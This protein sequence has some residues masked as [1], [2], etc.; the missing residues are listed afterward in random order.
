VNKENSIKFNVSA[1]CALVYLPL[2]LL[3]SWIGYHL[4]RRNTLQFSVEIHWEIQ[5]WV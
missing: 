2:S 3:K 5:K 4:L 1:V